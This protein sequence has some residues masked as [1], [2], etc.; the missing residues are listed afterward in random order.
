MLRVMFKSTVALV[1][2]AAFSFFSGCA[3]VE[4]GSVGIIKSW[5][6][7]I[8]TEPATG[9]NLLLLSSMPAQVDT[10][11][12]RVELKGLHPSD[13]NG[14]LV[15]DVGVVVS[16]TLNP[17][18]VPT[19]YIRTKEL[20]TYRDESGRMITTVGLK[21]LEN[22][23]QH[24][25]QELTKKQVMVELAGNLTDYESA[26]VKQSQ[27]ELDKGYPGVFNIIRVNVNHFIPPKAILDQ[28]NLIAGLKVEAARIDQEQTL[29]L[30]RT[31]LEAAKASVE[32]NALRVAMD[33][34]HLSAADLIAWKNARAY[35]VQARAIGDSAVRTVN[36]AAQPLAPKAN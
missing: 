1:A 6:G 16:F 22:I 17:A 31:A 34:S 3:R 4:T 24:A 26:I 8:S 35:E 9:F 33:S 23:V 5:R 32:A 25:I 29:I 15:D 20:D 36:A 19:F 28:A 18:A 30:K 10:T 13:A 27:A 12:T 11:E 7:E 14:V 2:V 21:V